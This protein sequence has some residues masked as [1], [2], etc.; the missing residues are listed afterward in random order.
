MISEKIIDCIISSAKT[1]S[2]DKLIKMLLENIQGGFNYNDDKVNHVLELLVDK[3]SYIGILDVNVAYV[4]EHLELL[5]YN[6]ENYNIKDI[7]ISR[8]DNL[9]ANILFSFAYLE[10]VN[11]DR[12]DVS[13][14][15]TTRNV[16]YINYPE[17]LKLR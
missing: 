2:K 15:N 9:N 10:K 7:K 3:S 6:H 13:Y 11:E 12:D 16:N 17:I 5:M 4:Q 8:I 14:T 1:E